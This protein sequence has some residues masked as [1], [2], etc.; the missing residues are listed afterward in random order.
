MPY[1][2]VPSMHEFSYFTLTDFVRYKP[3]DNI[4]FKAYA[5]HQREK[6]WREAYVCHSAFCDIR[7]NRKF[8]FCVAINCFKNTQDL[9]LKKADLSSF[10]F[11]FL[12]V[13]LG[14]R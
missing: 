4:A 6:I 7:S 2:C 11:E 8:Q 1:V 5:L 12:P 9:L 14:P 3:L 13:Y 10:Y